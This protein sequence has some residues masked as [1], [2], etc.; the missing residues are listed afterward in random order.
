MPCDQ[1]PCRCRAL[2]APCAR[3]RESF[4]CRTA[5]LVG[6]DEQR[7]LVQRGDGLRHDKGLAGACS[8]LEHDPRLTALQLG[9]QSGDGRRLVALR[10]G[11]KEIGR[12]RRLF[13]G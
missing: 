3:E 9:H 2:E 1:R 7:R 5:R 4:A 8:A 11:E 13:D 10:A 12:E 6:R